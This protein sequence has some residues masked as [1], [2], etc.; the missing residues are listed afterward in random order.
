M[1]SLQSKPQLVH[2][3][4]R[5][6]YKVSKKLY[7]SIERLLKTMSKQSKNTLPPARS[8][9]EQERRN[10]Q[11]ASVMAERQLS[12]GTASPSVVVHYLKAGSYSEQLDIEKKKEEIKLLQ[13]KTQSIE[14][15]AKIEGMFSDAI[16]AMK[17]YSGNNVGD[18]D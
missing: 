5:L 2:K 4:G 1:K 18:D 14:N 6:L 12:E 3:S 15:A 10:I 11:L 7:S 9:E 16:E 17:T 13:A 8:P